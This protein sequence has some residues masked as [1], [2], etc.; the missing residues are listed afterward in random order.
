MIV[1]F[2]TFLTEQYKNTNASSIV[3]KYEEVQREWPQPEIIKNTAKGCKK[4]HGLF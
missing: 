2:V 4:L 1:A 3:K